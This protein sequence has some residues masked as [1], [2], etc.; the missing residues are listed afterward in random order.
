MYRLIL[1]R[2]K[3][4]LRSPRG[5]KD[6]SSGGSD[7]LGALEAILIDLKES[8]DGTR[9]LR[10]RLSLSRLIIVVNALRV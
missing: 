1:D 9:H 10:L 7:A 6:L 2:V 3:K 8:A 4:H 5:R